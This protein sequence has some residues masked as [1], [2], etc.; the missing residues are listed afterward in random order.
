MIFRTVKK[1]FLL[2]FMLF[3]FFAVSHTVVYATKY[4]LIAPTGT[5]TRGQNVPFTLNVNTEGASMSSASVG[6]TYKTEYLQYTSISPGDTFSTVSATP[7]SDGNLS[8]TASQ[9][10]GFNG[11]GT[12]ATINFKLIATA[13]GSTELCTLTTPTTPPTITNTPP[14]GTTATS[15]ATPTRLPTTGGV[16][17]TVQNLLFGAAF[18]ALAGGLIWMNMKGKLH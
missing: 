2:L 12:L 5:L 1:I 7:E 8:I 10:P 13:P 18:I 9:S 15:S 4:E 14:P 11:S 17:S 16:D 6:L 3:L